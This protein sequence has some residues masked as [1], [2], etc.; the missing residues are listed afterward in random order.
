FLSDALGEANDGVPH[1]LDAMREGRSLVRTEH[2]V[3][4]HRIAEHQAMLLAVFGNVRFAAVD[5]LARCAAC[6]V[7]SEQIDRAS[8]RRSKSAQ[9]LDQLGLAVALHPRDAQDLAGADLQ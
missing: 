4:G 2:E 1:D 3:V 9:R 5:E 8:N 6:N 7:A